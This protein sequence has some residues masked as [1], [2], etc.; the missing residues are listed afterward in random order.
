MFTQ[1]GPNK[2]GH[3]T[4]RKTTTLIRLTVYIFKTPEPIC[5]MFGTLQRRFVLN[6]C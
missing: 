4:V 3:Y 2:R 6:Y 5:I 1:V